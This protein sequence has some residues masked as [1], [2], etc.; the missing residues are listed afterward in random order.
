MLQ[1]ILNVVDGSMNI[2]DAVN[3]PRVHHQ[4][5]P[6]V[7]QFEP[8]TLPPETIAALDRMGHRVRAFVLPPGAT[9]MPFT[10]NS[11]FVDARTG[12]RYGAADRHGPAGSTGAAGY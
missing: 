11:I 8:G 5:L 6:D 12:T 4:W 7:I 2:A 3:A 10:A 1:V 9:T